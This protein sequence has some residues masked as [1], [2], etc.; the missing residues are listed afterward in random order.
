V[1]QDFDLN[2]KITDAQAA[3]VSAACWMYVHIGTGHLEVI[4]DYMRQGMIPARREADQERASVE[5]DQFMAARRQILEIKRLIGHRADTLSG[6]P[7]NHPH[8]HASV[9]EAL[10]V[11][12]YLYH[13]LNDPKV[14][15]VSLDVSG[16]R[17]IAVSAACD[18]YT[19]VCMGQMEEIVE[20]VRMSVIPAARHETEERAG[21]HYETVEKIDGHV[22]ALKR[23]L[24]HHPN[25]SLGVGHPHVDLSAKRAWEVKKAIDKAIA[26]H[27]D[28]NPG[29]RG[30]NYDGND[31]RYTRDPVPVATVQDRS[32]APTP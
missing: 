10:E 12:G 9:L 13:L 2:L 15:D 30:V 25:S 20:L 16:H 26:V 6:H 1:S 7:V 23:A 32:A 14:T 5:P 24:G 28:P 21:V 27:R 8:T 11:R 4:L 31:L 17:A 3:A 18:L 22:A 29:F 19:R